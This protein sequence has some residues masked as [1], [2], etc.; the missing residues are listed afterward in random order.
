LQARCDRPTSNSK[1]YSGS[2]AIMRIL[3]L[4]PE[5]T[6][7]G[8][9]ITTFYRTLVSAL[10][11]RG[12]NVDIV[13]G[14]AC[15][16]EADRNRKNLWEGVCVET[17][18]VDRLA[19][20]RRKFPAFDAAPGLRDHLAAA[21]A[22]WEQ[23]GFGEDYDLIEASDWGLLFVPPAIEAMRP[24][25]VQ[26]HGSVGQIA[27]HDPIAGEETQ[28]VLAR[29]IERAVLSFTKCVQAYSHANAA[30]WEAET[31][32]DVTMLRPAV[33]LPPV[34]TSNV[35]SRGLV[36]GRV[37]RWKGPDVLCSALQRLGSAA[38]IFDWVGRDT[39]WDARQKS[40]VS[41]LACVAPAVWGSKVVHCQPEEPHVIAQ[42]QAT[43]LVN[44]VPST[45][46]TFNFTAAEAL[47]SGRP[48]IISSGAG[49]SELITDTENGYLFEAGDADGLAA[50][51]DRA[52]SESPA[53]LATIGAAGR[54][55]VHTILN[56]A[57]IADQR[58]AAYQAAIHCFRWLPP[59]PATGWLGDIC[60][61][62]TVPSRGTV[63]PY[64]NH[65]P[66][67]TLAAHLLARS[68][69]KVIAR[70]Y[71]QIYSR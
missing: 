6:T 41:H 19:R 21:W 63:F 65:L 13:Q 2:N 16:A 59:S 14:S 34:Y 7:H 40:A 32:Q 71:R 28:G 47:A 51:L 36:V 15:Y 69:Q 27:V 37:Q 43:A 31:G 45:W 4:T 22:M 1:Y 61:S 67:R 30:F 42:R 38:P 70:V 66:M 35:R 17:L 56:P 49:A 33:T 57:V 62:S 64:L 25:V 20:W 10:A 50:T 29:L 68:R 48:T 26:C 52:L 9:G 54:Q 3:L 44:V 46:D 60:R 8:G 53:R 55:T 24:L 58:I 18:E 11:A 12:V 39:A 5:F 23:A